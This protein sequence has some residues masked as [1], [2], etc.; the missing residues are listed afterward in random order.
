MG[1]LK[2]VEADED[3]R[4]NRDFCPHRYDRG[5]AFDGMHA[6]IKGHDSAG[7]GLLPAHGSPMWRSHHAVFALVL[8]GGRFL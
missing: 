8:Q 5:S 7:E 1:T 2:L 6:A 4:Q 3:Y